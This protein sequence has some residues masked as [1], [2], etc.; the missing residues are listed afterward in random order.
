MLPDKSCRCYCTLAGTWWSTGVR[1][2]PGRL[3]SASRIRACFWYHNCP[4]TSDTL[5]SRDLQTRTQPIHMNA[6]CHICIHSC[7]FM[8]FCFSLFGWLHVLNVLNVCTF[9]CM[10]V[11][12]YLYMLACVCAVGL[13]V[14]MYVCSYIGIYVGIFEYMNVCMHTCMRVCMHLWRYVFMCVRTFV[15]MLARMYVQP[16]PHRLKI[17]TY[18]AQFANRKSDRKSS[19]P[20]PPCLFWYIDPQETCRFCGMSFSASPSIRNSWN[21]LLVCMFKCM[22]ECLHTYLNAFV[23]VRD[24]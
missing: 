1:D 11:Y 20:K 22:Y 16:I 21:G 10:Y 7:I 9:A 2:A 14:C 4:W 18:P 13:F 17:R 19:N 15:R 5:P 8:C 24:T 23:C 3:L 12:T 6:S